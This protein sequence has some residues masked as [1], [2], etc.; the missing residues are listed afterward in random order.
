MMQFDLDLLQESFEKCYIGE[1]DLE[2]YNRGYEELYKFFGI[3]GSVFNFVASD[4]REKIDI[5]VSIYSLSFISTY[6][7][8]KANKNR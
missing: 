5:L 1:M 7:K 8:M 6:D 3:I 2:Q 4:V